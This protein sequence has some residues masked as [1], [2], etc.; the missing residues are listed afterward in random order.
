MNKFIISG[1]VAKNLTLKCTT[2]GTNLT[3]ICIADNY[4][5]VKDGQKVEK[6][7]FFYISAYGDIAKN[8][9]KHCGKGSYIIIEAR[10][11]NDN[12]EKDGKKIYTNQIIASKIEFVSLKSPN[13]PIF[14]YDPDRDLD[15]TPE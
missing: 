15:Q 4:S 9:V 14:E 8:V 11:E 1:Y 2:S 13:E 5:Y 6:T 12:Y 3:S 10:L 7:N